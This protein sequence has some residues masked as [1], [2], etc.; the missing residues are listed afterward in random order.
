M[1]VLRARRV[2]AAAVVF[3]GGEAV[4]RRVVLWQGDVARAVGGMPPLAVGGVINRLACG[5]Q[6]AVRVAAAVF[7]VV[8]VD[9]GG[10]VFAG[11]AGAVT[12]EAEGFAAEVVAVIEHR[13]EAGVEAGGV[14]V[15]GFAAVDEAGG[16]GVIT[17]AGVVDAREVGVRLDAILLNG[18]W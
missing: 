3:D 16:E 5:E 10:E 1:P 2:V 6:G 12:E 11:A 18:R 15:A 14:A 17:R 9:D 8:G 7:A 4:R 13:G